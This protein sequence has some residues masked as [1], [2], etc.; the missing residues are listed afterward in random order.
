M[1]NSA[2]ATTDAISYPLFIPGKPHIGSPG[3]LL[4]RNWR[5]RMRDPE[6]IQTVVIGAGQAGLSVGYHLAKRGVPFV[7]LESNARVGDT[8]RQRWDSLRLFTP[9]V[10]DSLVGM[11]FPAPGRSFPTKEDMANY[12]ESYARQFRLPVRTGVT[13]R[14]VSRQDGKFFV[15]TSTGDIIAENVVVAMASYQKPRRP[16][17]AEA[18][19]PTIA[20]FHSSAYRNPKQ[21]APGGVLVVG[22]GN[23]GAEIALEA[24]K[25]G[26]KTW[27]SG[28]NTGHVPFRIESAIGRW[29]LAPI[30]LRFVFH[31]L[32]TLNT[33][34]G[35]KAHA[36]PAQSTPLIRTRPRELE[37]AGI[38][39]VGRT[40]GVE[41]GLPRL[42]DGR[43]LDVNTVI[44]CTGFDAGLSWID[45]PV[46]D[47]RGAPMHHR[48]IVEREPGLFF[49]GVHFLFAMSSTMIHGA[50]RDAEYVANAV[51]ARARMNHRVTS[52]IDMM[53]S[54][55][56]IPST[57]PIPSTTS[58][59]TV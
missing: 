7:I 20:Q 54:P 38:T 45:L 24:A 35:R 30:L 21:F 56:M 40:I 48:G 42:E 12:L 53:V 57:T 10:F 29:V 14:R 26:H 22:A 47:S 44:W 37:N 11:R 17:F 50:A 16:A 32:L 59:K 36:A 27:I 58:A 51:I 13:V 23:S 5:E 43:S 33:P 19:S 49:T 4:A 25:N 3:Q 41:H 52:A 15:E 55:S 2:D 34:V 18:L 1:H 39:R 46:F 31:R 8:W 9:A 6:R 28:R